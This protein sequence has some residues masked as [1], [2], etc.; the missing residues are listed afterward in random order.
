MSN[1][2][3]VLGL[4]S[5]TVSPLGKGV[6]WRFLVENFQEDLKIIEL[7]N[8]SITKQSIEQQLFQFIQFK[9]E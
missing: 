2:P 9:T 6:V 4:Y 5:L 3:D 7:K 8:K 1:F